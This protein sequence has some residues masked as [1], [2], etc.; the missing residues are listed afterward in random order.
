MSERPQGEPV[1]C[2]ALVVS[3]GALLLAATASQPGRRLLTPLF[4]ALAA[5]PSPPAA[6][7][8]PGPDLS[9]ELEVLRDEIRLVREERMTARKERLEAVAAG[10]VERGRRQY[11]R[12]ALENRCRDTIAVA[13]HYRDIDGAMITRGWWEVA[14]GATVITDAATRDDAF[15]VYAENQ[16][17]GRTWDGRGA[18]GAASKTISDLKFDQLDGEAVILAS[19]RSVSFA[20][21]S[22]GPQWTDSTETFECPAEEA[23][24]KGTIAK[25]PASGQGPR[26]P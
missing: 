12:I 21:R 22:T 18:D 13:L 19:P 25:P 14:A 3:L 26:R 17:V 20:K 6:A 16:A 10:Y 23:P 2:V 24:P 1:G 7:A 5:S 15:W 9:S 4:P 8:S 11:H